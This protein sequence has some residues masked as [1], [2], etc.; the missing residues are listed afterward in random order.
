MI[1]MTTMPSR[2]SPKHR[3]GGRRQRASRLVGVAGA[4]LAGIMGLSTTIAFA[5]GPNPA[6]KADARS[7]LTPVAVFDADDRTAVPPR[8]DWVAQRIGILFNNRAR[9]V[10]TAFCV[11]DNIIATAAHCFAKGQSPGS[12]RYADFNFAR[13]YDRA[14]SFVRLEGA[15]TG[16]AAQHVTSGDFRLRVRPPIDAAH[17]WAL[18]RVPRNTCPADSLKVE[19][20][21]LNALIA[22]SAAGRIFQVSYHRDWAQW[23]PSY[24]KPCAIARDF[25]R[26]AWPSI[27]PDFI[28]PEH[29]VLHTCD[30]GGASSGSPLLKQTA[31]GAVVVAINVGTYVQSRS[32]VQGTELS[33]RQRSETIANTA[34]NAEAFVARLD[35]LRD[36]NIVATGPLIR[37]LQE[38]LAQR[39]HYTGKM[40]GSYGPAL[41]TAIEAYEQTGGLL[42]TGL[43]TEALRKRLMSEAARAASPSPQK[44]TSGTG[45]VPPR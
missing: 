43:A 30:T 16:A 11:A 33:A 5:T 27:A 9:T 13:N 38:M 15:A 17:D 24:S 37:Q 34:V 25:E 40:D 28:K 1:P 32:T 41:K 19:A 7:M 20:M 14:R 26:I 18:A 8:L 3:P 45:T 22:E 36:A 31:A 29:M 42:V 4:I 10:C 35:A 6:F 12:I 2:P 39:G 23:R 21:P 44:P